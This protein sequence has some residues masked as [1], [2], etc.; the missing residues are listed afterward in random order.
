M[1]KLNS[2]AYI[3]DFDGTMMHTLPLWRDLDRSYLAKHGIEVPDDLQRAIEGMN[4]S[5]CAGYFR[6]RFGISDPEDMIIAE[7]MAIIHQQIVAHPLKDDVVRFLDQTDR[8]LA[9]ATSNSRLIIE[10]VLYVNQLHHR[11]SAIVTSDDVGQ[12][13]PA[14]AIFLRAANLLGHD[15]MDCAVFEDTEAGIVGAKRAGMTTVAV[16]DPSNPVWEQTADQADYAIVS[17][18]EISEE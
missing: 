5:D 6:S 10:D 17:F 2:P 8:R 18:D 11:F 16:Y 4:F 13:K 3:F 1:I 7:W 14:P 15:P 9:I 12:S